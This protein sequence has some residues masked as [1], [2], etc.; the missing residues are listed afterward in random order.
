MP[1]PFILT[2]I[3]IIAVCAAALVRQFLGDTFK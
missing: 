1:D 3:I 2:L